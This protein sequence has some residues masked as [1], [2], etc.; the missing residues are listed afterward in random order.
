MSG[1]GSSPDPEHHFGQRIAS[2]FGI[3]TVVEHTAIGFL[4]DGG[5]QVPAANVPDDAFA[6]IAHNTYEENLESIIVNG[7]LAGGGGIADA[8]HSQLSAFHIGDNR[9]QESSRGSTTTAAIHS[10]ISKPLVNIC[11]SGVIAKRKRLPGS[12]IERIWVKREVPVRIRDGRTVMTRRWITHVD[13]RAADLR[14]TG[15]IGARKSG[16]SDEFKAAIKRLNKHSRSMAFEDAFKDMALSRGYGD[17]L[18]KCC[19][20][21]G[22]PMLQM[23]TACFKCG[24]IATYEGSNAKSIISVE[25]LKKVEDVALVARVGLAPRVTIATAS[26]ALAQPTVGEEEEKKDLTELEAN[27]KL[28]AR[29]LEYKGS[30]QLISTRAI[31]AKAVFRSIQHRLAWRADPKQAADDTSAEGEGTYSLD[32]IKPYAAA[33]Y[34]PYWMQKGDGPSWVPVDRWDTLPR[35]QTTDLPETEWAMWLAGVVDEIENAGGMNDLKVIENKHHA[36]REAIVDKVCVQV[37]GTKNPT[38]ESVVLRH[39]PMVARMFAKGSQ[40][41]AN[42][43]RRFRAKVASI[44]Q[45]FCEQILTGPQLERA[46]AASAYGQRGLSKA[47][48]AADLRYRTK[49]PPRER[50]STPPAKR[51]TLKSRPRSPGRPVLTLVGSLGVTAPFPHLATA[52]RARPNT[53]SPIGKKGQ[54]AASVVARAP[55]PSITPEERANLEMRAKASAGKR[56][57]MCVAVAP[58]PIAAIP[59]LSP[60]AKSS[61]STPRAGSPGSQ[62]KGGGTPPLHGTVVVVAAAAAATLPAADAAEAFTCSVDDAYNQHCTM[63]HTAGFEFPWLAFTTF[64][65]LFAAVVTCTIFLLVR[66]WQRRRVMPVED[67]HEADVDTAHLRLDRPARLW[68]PDSSGEEVCFIRTRENDA[69]VEITVRD[70]G[71]QTSTWQSYSSNELENEIAFRLSNDAFSMSY[72]HPVPLRPGYTKRHQYK[73]LGAICNSTT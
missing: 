68:E 71:V 31:M 29:I 6:C 51:I 21:C 25:A 69:Q 39:G 41:R 56:A 7:L 70:L 17:F 72:E 46:R 8:V 27:E 14:I 33:G 52:K 26:L 73:A 19:P 66:W 57:V 2:V 48:S 18:C 62:K 65:V 1:S 61:L 43:A 42:K 5:L 67:S 50:S 12:F 64:V 38:K 9:L 45:D 44:I 47:A 10:S 34:L 28:M 24:M 11:A 23:Q 32:R 15:W 35:N 30:T 59:A 55:L 40:G 49:S 13:R 4:E 16:Y 37:F 36:F 3:R 54:Q 60:V 58:V 53:R 20:Q 63:I 22:S